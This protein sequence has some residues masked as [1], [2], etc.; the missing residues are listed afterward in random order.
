MLKKKIEKNWN[1]N[2]ESIITAVV[3]MS[4]VGGFFILGKRYQKA[5]TITHIKD[6]VTLT[7]SIDPIFPEYMSIPEIKKVLSTMANTSFADALV[8][9]IDGDQ[10]LIVRAAEALTI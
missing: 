8:V 1:E 7:K 10:R 9:N 3:V 5:N 4:V 2:K 6:A